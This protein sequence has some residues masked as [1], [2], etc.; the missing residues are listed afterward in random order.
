MTHRYICPIPF[1]FTRTLKS[2]FLFKPFTVRR[3]TGSY[4]VARARK[5]KYELDRSQPACASF[6]QVNCFGTRSFAAAELP[7]M[8][9]N[10]SHTL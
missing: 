1:F 8:D 6:I 10:Q 3:T 5:L 7:E 9:M 4:P 2:A